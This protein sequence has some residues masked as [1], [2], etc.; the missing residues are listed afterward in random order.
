MLR[1]RGLFTCRRVIVAGCLVV[2]A[3]VALLL[4]LWP[5]QDLDAQ[6]RAIDAAYAIPEEENAASAYTELAWGYSGLSLTYHTDY[7]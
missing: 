7:D 6:L 1:V 2:M 4:L 3:A 5:G